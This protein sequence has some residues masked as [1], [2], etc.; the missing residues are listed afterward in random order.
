M[1]AFKE[2]TF[3]QLHSQRLNFFEYRRPIKY[4][5][6]FYIRCFSERMWVVTVVKI[7]VF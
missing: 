5:P 1:K 4:A 3:S 7:V 6:R 2:E